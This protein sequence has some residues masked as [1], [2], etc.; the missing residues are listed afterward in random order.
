MLDG[1]QRRWCPSGRLS[2]TYLNLR[3]WMAKDCL[4]PFSPAHGLRFFESP[5]VSDLC[6]AARFAQRHGSSHTLIIFTCR[7]SYSP[8]K[9]STVESLTTI[10]TDAGNSRFLRKAETVV[11]SY[12]DNHCSA[13]GIHVGFILVMTHAPPKAISPAYT[14]CGSIAMSAEIS[15]T[16]APST[17]CTAFSRSFATL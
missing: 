17:D 12:L 8:Q 9:A 10:E 5:R 4:I 6:R 11:W 16:I 15:P 2:T 14:I 13:I 1:R 7:F 3:H